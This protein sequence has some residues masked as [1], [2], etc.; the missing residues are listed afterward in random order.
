MSL[1]QDS[2]SN[3][4]PA[5]S[6]QP[7][8]VVVATILRADGTTGVHTHV[9]EFL[10]HL[11]AVGQPYHLVTPLSRSPGLAT[12]LFAPRVALSRL[13]QPLAVLWYRYWHRLFLSAAL[14]RLLASLPHA[15]VYAQSPEAAAAALRARSGR[16]QRVVM[17]VHFQ[18]S[19]ADGWQ[20]KGDIKPG[21]ITA[22]RIKDSETRIISELDGLLYL[23]ESARDNLIA[24]HPEADYVASEI[25]HNFVA[26]PPNHGRTNLVGDLVTVGGLDSHKN[27]KFLIDVLATIKARG[28]DLT[29]DLFGTGPCET[30]LRRQAIS[31]GVA[32][33][34]RFQGF[35]SDVRR[36]LPHYRLYVHASRTEVGPLAIIEAMAAGLPIVAGKVGGIAE[37]LTDGFE[38][39]FWSLSDPE[40][41]ATT[42]LELLDDEKAIRA[43][44][45]AASERFATQFDAATVAPGLL[46]FLIHGPHRLLSTAAST[47]PAAGLDR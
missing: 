25:V 17:A 13:S 14:R 26:S 37:F 27:H 34:V 4:A 10:R 19:Q 28:R 11:D 39:R 38:G 12:L 1:M 42:L 8:V 36:H 44:S 22:R 35:R 3:A 46:S 31:L 21:S 6:M 7:P 41:A 20:E 5:P 29:L 40:S 43:A 2:I 15:V 45:A 16:Q 9:R 18:G 24:S 23:S 47:T 33:Q 32:H 30:E